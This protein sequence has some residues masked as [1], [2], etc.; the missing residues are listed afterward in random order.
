MTNIILDTNILI[1]LV[2][3]NAI[4]QQVK[5]YVGS[6]TEPQLFVSVVNITEAESLVVQWKWPND[7]IERLKILITSFIAIDIEQNNNELLNAYITIDAFSQ[8]KTFAPNGQPLNN[9]S[10]NM[11]KNDLWIA[12]TAYAMNAQLL[13][14]DGDFDHLD[15]SFFIVKKYA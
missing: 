13:T 9:S 6:I 8:G 1:H 10:R 15:N 2:R 7:K 12:A 3:G 11:G 5:N 14:T 4:A